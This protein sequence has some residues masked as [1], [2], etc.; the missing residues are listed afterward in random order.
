MA[1]KGRDQMKRDKNVEQEDQQSMEKINA[2]MIRHA[3]QIAHE[4]GATAILVY[5]DAVW[6]TKNMESLIR[7]GKCILAARSGEVIEHLAS[8]KGAE[9]HIIRVPYMNLTRYSQ[10]K[11]A[12]MLALSK[13]LIGH[14]DR[15]ICLAGS[16]EYGILDSLTVLDVGREF[17]V[18]SSSNLE[19][20]RR[21]PFP[22]VF[23]RLLT[24]ALE[25]A[26]EGKEGKPVGTIFVF[27]DHEEVLRLSSQMVINP[28]AAVPDQ[29]RNIMNPSLKETIREFST[30]DGAFVVREDGVILAA[31]RHLKA[32]LESPDIPQGLG[33]R[34]RA[35]AGISE[36]TNAMAIAISESTGDVRIFSQGKLFMQI[37]RAKKER[38]HR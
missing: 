32:S 20:T 25:L 2:A 34:H 38:Y 3:W 6:S 14:G 9:Q 23:D 31:G 36:V 12:A 4:I 11:V 26:E 7:Q 30:I 27:G 21:M 22:H 35:A 10:I 13:G 5:V 29:E 15:L 33:A 24:I 28:F 8:M 18:F 16:S 19:M 1:R 37:E 17:E